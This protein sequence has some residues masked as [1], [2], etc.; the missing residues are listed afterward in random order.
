[1][2]SRDMIGLLLTSQCH[3]EV[4]RL[5]HRTEHLAVTFATFAGIVGLSQFH[6]P[7]LT[8]INNDRQLR[9]LL[10][11]NERKRLI[12]R[13]AGHDDRQDLANIYREG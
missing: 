8:Q 7:N 1:M 5:S 2:T 11:N 3:F 12:E 6:A 13:P 9:A 4:G 10:D